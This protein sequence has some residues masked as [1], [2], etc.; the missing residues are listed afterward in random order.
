MHEVCQ[1]EACI[2]RANEIIYKIFYK[3]KKKK[4]KKK[5]LLALRAFVLFW[6]HP[7]CELSGVPFSFG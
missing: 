2:S 4:K 1:V 5:N 6:C 3:K 7:L